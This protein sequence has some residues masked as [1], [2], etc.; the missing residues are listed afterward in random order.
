MKTKFILLFLI[1]F[2]L[3]FAQNI[4][5]ID[6]EKKPNGTKIIKHM[7]TKCFDVQRIKI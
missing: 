5:N 4:E 1:N 3:F 2:Q 6:I 7:C